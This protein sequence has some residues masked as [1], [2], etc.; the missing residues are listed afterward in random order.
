M[1]RRSLSDGKYL[2]YSGGFHAPTD[3]S[4]EF[5]SVAGK[6]EKPIAEVE[7]ENEHEETTGKDHEDQHDGMT[8][9]ERASTIEEYKQMLTRCNDEYTSLQTAMNMIQ[10]PH[11]AE[12][13]WLR[14]AVRRSFPAVEIAPR[15]SPRA[16]S[17]STSKRKRDGDSAEL[18]NRRRSMSNDVAD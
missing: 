15:A 2:A 6:D 10:F 18:S 8:E 11:E 9:E 3:I 5:E 13:F 12:S 1:F 4:E 16:E 14:Y 17:R 7:T